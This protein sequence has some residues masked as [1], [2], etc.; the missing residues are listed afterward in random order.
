MR[1]DSFLAVQWIAREMQVVNGAIFVRLGESM[2]CKSW[3]TFPVNTDESNS[4]LYP[5]SL[6]CSGSRQRHGADR[7]LGGSNLI[8]LWLSSGTAP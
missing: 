1:A 8:D 2:D 3:S 4:C 7:Y 5:E 6:G